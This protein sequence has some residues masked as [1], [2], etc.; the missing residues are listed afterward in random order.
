MLTRSLRLDARAP[1]AT[2]LGYE[3]G[4]RVFGML[5][6]AWSGQVLALYGVSLFVGIW[7]LVVCGT[8]AHPRARPLDQTDPSL[9]F[10]LLVCLVHLD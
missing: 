7:F 3:L 10:L 1:G 8:R 9:S 4:G 2:G 6:D 5:A